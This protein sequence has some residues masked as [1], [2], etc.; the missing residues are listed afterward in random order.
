[1]A[2]PKAIQQ[3]VDDAE[4]LERQMMDAKSETAPPEPPPPEPE[5]PVVKPEVPAQPDVWKH[6][7]DTLQGMFN[8][9][10]AQWTEQRKTM[11]ADIQA[12]HMKIADLASVQ[13][14]QANVTADTDEKDVEMFGTDMVELTR[15]IARKEAAKVEAVFEQ[16]LSA[17]DNYIKQLEAKVGTVSD[18]QQVSERDRFTAELGM[19][20]PDWQAI[21]ADQGF[22]LWLGELDP[23]YGMPRQ[24]A[25][26]V[27]ANAA[28]ANRVA[29]I[30]NAYKALANGTPATNV[31]LERQV[32]PPK[33]RS[34]PVV[35]ANS[36]TKIWPEGE[37]K[38]FYDAWRRGEYTQEQATAIE[39]EIDVAVMEGRVRR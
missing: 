15:R 11:E 31:E 1:M 9:Q 2:L 3:Q 33:T 39:A 14:T 12:L 13:A 18:K 29:A 35:A 28:D 5:A 24:A 25:L 10:S 8:A 23:I 32:A 38:Q 20:V 21:N 37:I 4:A 22:L 16:Q 7:Y 30:F 17:R 36:K 26:D 27:A 6:K 19:K 34:G